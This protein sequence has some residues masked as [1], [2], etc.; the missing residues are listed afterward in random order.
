M[1][2]SS[3][4]IVRIDADAIVDWASFHD[5]FAQSL[6]FPGFYGRNLNAWIDCMTYVDDVDAG[7]TTVHVASGQVLTLVIENAAAFRARCP[8]QF[9]ALVEDAAFVNWRRIAQG[10]PAVLALAFRA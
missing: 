4:A 7:M 3:S 2:A 5:V 6:G 9:A 8:G 1:E 10:Q